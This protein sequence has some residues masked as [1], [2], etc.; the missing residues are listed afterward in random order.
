MD[1]MKS[2]KMD[3]IQM[4]ED[5][6][7]METPSV[8]KPLLDKFANHLL[9]II[10]HITGLKCEL[11]RSESSGNIIRCIFNPDAQEQ[12]LLLTH[13]DTVFD[14]GTTKKNPFRIESGKAYGPG[15]FDM[16]GGLVQTIFAMEYLVRNKTIKNKVV[17]LITSDEEV[18]SAFSRSI[19]EEEAKRSKFALVMEA[20]LNGNLKTERKGVGTIMLKTTGKA[21][22]AGLDPKKGINAIN[23]MSS[24]IE[25]IKNFSAGINDGTLINIGTIHGG[26][27]TNVIPDICEIGIDVRYSS[28]ESAENVLLFLKS[29]K[30]GLAGST[31]SVTYRMR[32]PMTRT[33]LTKDLFQKVKLLA[34]NIG[35]NINEVSVSGASD[36]N[37]CSKYCPVIDGLGAVGDGAH[38]EN[39]YLLVD[40]L[41]ERSALLGLIMTM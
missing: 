13:Y 38:S 31:T 27:R 16:K 20:S 37:I 18:G 21:A 19:I 28:E 10:E 41:P 15:V 23:A 30:T 24:I 39:E 32:E 7:D 40:T 17:L 25:Q 35:L 5:F 2:R 3:M 29:L 34:S 1:Y 22:H 6:V 9:D 4:L 12:I 26:T 14:V 36:G 33:D 11:I 8:N